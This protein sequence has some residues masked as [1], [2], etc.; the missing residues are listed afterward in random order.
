MILD[1]LE[2]S[3]KYNYTNGNFSKAFSFLLNTDLIN[4]DDGRYE[5]DG[6]NVYAIISSYDTKSPEGAHPEAHRVYADIQYMVSGTEQIG[7]SVYNGQK[8]FKEYNAEKDFLLYENVSFFIKMETGMF[9]VFYPDD[10]HMPGIMINNPA[11][12][13]KAVI[14][15]KL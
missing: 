5:I 10:L 13:K 1:K 15:V 6:D 4:I 12:V 3:A 9:A 8:V 2:N 11:P 7:Y 14:K